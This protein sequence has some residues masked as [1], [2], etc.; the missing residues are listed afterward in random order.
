MELSSSWTLMKAGLKGTPDLGNWLCQNLQSGDAVGIDPSV[1]AAMP[2]LELQ[3]KLRKVG[4]EL[5]SLQP[6]LVDQIWQSCGVEPTEPVRLHPVKLAGIGTPEKLRQVRRKMVDN[7]ADVLL[8]T[9]LD[10]VAPLGQVWGQM[11]MQACSKLAK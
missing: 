3:G 7:K 4:I 5:R 1:H 8:V 9:A 11:N 10:E 6:N 2:A